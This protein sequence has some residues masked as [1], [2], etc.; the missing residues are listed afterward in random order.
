MKSLVYLRPLLASDEAIFLQ[1]VR[2]S[3]RL[4]RPWVSPP[5][6]AHA[7][8][9]YLDAMAAPVNVTFALVQHS[10]EAIVGVINLTQI[11]RGC[12]QS[13]YLGYYIFA[14]YERQG[15]MREGLR[16]AVRHAFGMLKLHRVEANIQ[17]NNAA[18]LALVAACGFRKEGYSPRYLK[19][20]GRW[21][22]H[23]RWAICA[24]G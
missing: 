19:V 23:E 21:R 12:F 2:L 10:T 18:S 22:D 9:Q 17:P 16:L 4:H 11:V 8:R 5:A 14:G 7:F 1:A 24:S 15:L 3:R 20:G 13:A 6:T